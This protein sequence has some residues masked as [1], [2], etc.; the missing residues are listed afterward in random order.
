[1]I[2]HFTKEQFEAA[3]PKSAKFSVESVGINSNEYCYLLIINEK[4]R[5]FIRSSVGPK[6][7][8]AEVGEDSIRTFL[9]D[10]NG[11][12]FAPKVTKFTTRVKGWEERMRENMRFLIRLHQQAG[13]DGD[14]PREIRK[15]SKEG[16]NK[17][18]FFC[19]ETPT[20]PFTW[21]T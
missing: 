19:P 10:N 21:L 14:K 15:V 4:A 13:F 9:V 2:E 1:M 8:S 12:P 16:P 18:R 5:V 3:L 6:G 7:V 20:K 17:G 11:R